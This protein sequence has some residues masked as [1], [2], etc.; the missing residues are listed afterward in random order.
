MV[1][2]L[3][4]KKLMEAVS[5]V[6]RFAG[7]KNTTLPTLTG[8]CIVA[9][10]GGIKLR[11]TNLEIGIDLHLEGKIEEEGV[12]V[13]PAQTLKEI[14]LSFDPTGEVKL[15]S[16]GESLTMRSKSGTS[17]L[18]TLPSD[19]FP[20]L[21]TA[22]TSGATL[23]FSSSD[24]ISLIQTVLPYA[25]TSMIR[26]ELASVYI[27][28]SG[29]TLTFVATDSFRLAEKKTTLSAHPEPFTVLIPAR[30]LALILSSLP[31][32]EVT[33]TIDEHQCEFRFTQGTITSRLTQGT[34]PDYTQ[35]IPKKFICE[36][37]LL[38][39]D[40]EHGLRRTSIFSD[41]FQKITLRT[42]PETKEI[43]LE[44]K[45][46]DVGETQE[47]LSGQVSGEEVQLSFNHKYLLAPLP[48]IPQDTITL[49]LSGIGRAAVI[50]GQNDASFLYLVMPMN[51]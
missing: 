10:D 28:N 50:R 18:R 49:S 38:K 16:D 24:L 42:S 43:V 26:P 35:I 34:Y 31:E 21:P 51:Q 5:V 45:N 1:L 11:A 8:I 23:S 14:C 27:Q 39:K 4:K 2:T 13:V 7:L 12:V 19:D 46:N 25:S 6:S 15:T 33:L 32:E 47:H 17:T 37:T 44:A 40:L 20:T 30:N 48:S 22:P 3:E 36:T 41:V 9:G 29:G